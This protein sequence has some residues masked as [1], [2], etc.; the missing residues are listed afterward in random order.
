M[1]QIAR[2]LNSLCLPLC[3]CGGS[4]PSAADHKPPPR[5]ERVVIDAD[6]PGGYQVEV[7]D[8][9]GDGKPDVVG[10]GGGTCAWY[11]N[12]SWKKR[13]VT[14]PKQ[15]PGIISSATADL[16][17]DGKAEVAIAYEFAMNEPTKGKLALAVQGGGPDDPWTVR[18]I[19]DLGSIHRLR[20]GDVAGDRRPE[21]VVAPIFGPKAH[22]PD[23]LDPARLTLF[24]TGD[25]PKS[26]R[27]KAEVQ[28]TRPVVH[29]I[30]VRDL[31]GDGRDEILTADNLGVALL[32][33][34]RPPSSRGP[35]LGLIRGAPG[36]PPKQ[37]S[38]EVHLGKLADGRRFLATIDPWHGNEVAICLA[39]SPGVP[40][41]DGSGSPLTLEFHPRSVID[42][43]LADGHALWVAD[44]DRDG[45]DEVFAGHR[46]KDH[47]VSVYNFNG[48]TWDRTVLD[49]DIAAQDLR[50][51]DLDGDGTPD[52]VAIGGSTHSVVWYRPR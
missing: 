22:P 50:G 49:R 41:S 34:R 46:G 51:G 14:T 43:T 17:G 23:Y 48:A 33:L 47:R 20:W 13:L 37:G 29:A 25:E 4:P 30:E 45:D 6:F 16:D 36:S 32:D 38:S 9:N 42:D 11:E 8:V 12:P 18:P 1:K 10:V 26:G 24:L 35:F 3:L 19:A 15:T 2:I 52:V 31:D 40:G 7:A 39:K 27:W 44:V 5:F 21:L 28:G